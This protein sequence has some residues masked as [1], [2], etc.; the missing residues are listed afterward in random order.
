MLED[1]MKRVLPAVFGLLGALS[2]LLPA[3]AQSLRANDTWG[4]RQLLEVP[5]KPTYVSA[6]RYR[7]SANA[8]GKWL[9]AR[10]KAPREQAP[11]STV[12]QIA[13]QLPADA[14]MLD[15]TLGEE[16]SLG[17]VCHMLLR[18]G[19]DW[20]I[21]SGTTLLGL[22]GRFE[23]KAIN[24]ALEVPAGT[25]NTTRIEGEYTRAEMAYPGVEPPE[26][27][28]VLRYR[29]TYW[30]S[31]QTRAM[32]KL[33]REKL[34]PSGKLIQRTTEELDSYPPL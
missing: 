5:G 12:W 25:F 30:F 16:V 1:S 29:H 28:Y 13:G 9:M 11:A 2:I 27:G 15:L 20:V 19:T 10:T 24:E 32:V 31:Q 6:P 26:Y 21:D 22:K 18:P 7:I 3:Q 33:V 8:D 14:C 34:T 23:V 4:Y 17:Q